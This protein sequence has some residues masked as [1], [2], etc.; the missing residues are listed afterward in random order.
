MKKYELYTA[1]KERFKSQQETHGF[2]NWEQYHDNF[3]LEC[4]NMK[5]PI[6][7]TIEPTIIHFWQNGN[8]YSIYRG[9][10]FNTDKLKEVIKELEI[11]KFHLSDDLSN[12][13]A[14]EVIEDALNI[15]ETLTKF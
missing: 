12:P 4:W 15:I 9:G 8:G 5:H 7:G 11:L 14:P 13:N 3:K 6:T 1:S 2:I 10:N